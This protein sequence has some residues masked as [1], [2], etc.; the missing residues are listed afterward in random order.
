MELVPGFFGEEQPCNFALWCVC[1][2]GFFF[3]VPLIF[4]PFR[5]SSDIGI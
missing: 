1:V 5:F 4:L 3:L 2:V